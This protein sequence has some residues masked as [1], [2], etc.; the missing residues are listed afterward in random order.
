MKKK[1]IFLTV[2]SLLLS[3][4]CAQN[5]MGFAEETDGDLVAPTLDVCPVDA[6]EV[7]VGMPVIVYY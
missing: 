6:S 4:F 1:L 5:V 7:Y 2:V 3:S